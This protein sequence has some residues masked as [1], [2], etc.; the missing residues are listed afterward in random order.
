MTTKRRLAMFA[1]SLLCLA[2]ARSRAQPTTAPVSPEER[3]EFQFTEVRFDRMPLEKAIATLAAQSHANLTVDWKSL[4][5][6]SVKRDTP[7]TLH[8][9]DLPLNK[10]LPLTL[11][12]ASDD[13]KAQ[14][15]FEVDDHGIAHIAAA[16]DL[17]GGLIRIYDVAS[18][19]EVPPAAATQP[20]PAPNGQG[21]YPGSTRQEK[22][23]ELVRLIET[24]VDANSWRD[25][26]G[27]TGAIREFAGNLVISQTRRNQQRIALLLDGIQA[28]HQSRAAGHPTTRPIEVRDLP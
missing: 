10:V 2:I 3:M 6:I 28:M 14:L 7:I 24:T 13:E 8:L 16:Q 12:Q 27:Q 26:G 1:A 18:L 11:E 17:T 5:A 21:P 20:V 25:N 9:F 15:G 23:D 4:G 19:L 22:V